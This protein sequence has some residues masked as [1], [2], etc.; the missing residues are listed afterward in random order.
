[1]PKSDF[2]FGTFD[3]STSAA[4]YKL[5]P[6][7]FPTP[8]KDVETFEVPG[9]SGDLLIDYGS[10]KNVELTVE[11]AIDGA[12]VDSDFITL[13]DALRA[14]IM[15]Q[16]G[17]Q[18]LEDSL[19]PNEYR[20]ARAVMCEREQS[21]T[22]SG[23][24]IFTFDAKP[25][26]YIETENPPIIPAPTGG[27][28]YFTASGVSNSIFNSGFISSHYYDEDLNKDVTVIDV[29][30][31]SQGT[32]VKATYPA[33]MVLSE[34]Y[35]QETCYNPLT[36]EAYNGWTSNSASLNEV[37]TS[38]TY[39]YESFWAS[40]KWHYD[41]E[42]EGFAYLII[43][44]PLSYEVLDASDN[45]IGSDFTDSMTITAPDGYNAAP[46]LYVNLPWNPPKTLTGQPILRINGSAVIRLFTPA[47]ITVGTTDY[48]VKEIF[49][50]TATYNAYC[51]LF[52][53]ASGVKYSMNKYIAVDGVLDFSGSETTI[54]YNGSILGGN[55]I[56]EWWKI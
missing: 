46:I 13:Y 41:D 43:E 20:M 44:T 56:P 49:F 12:A 3:T 1:M 2:V 39:T 7:N 4:Y 52:G 6:I 31:F 15:V 24:A 14:A 35:Y 21:D 45:V 19:Y 47:T 32:K 9:R 51:Y 55:F 11:I 42:S 30:N 23:K 5:Q 29:R 50:D 25:Q 28:T 34:I 53:L 17:Y 18:R 40:K 27:D 10:Y 16:S 54:E 48:I 33:G 8:E 38:T 36:N 22:Q 26:R 37:L